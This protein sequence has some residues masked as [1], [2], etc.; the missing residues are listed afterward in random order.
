MKRNLKLLTILFFIPLFTSAQVYFSEIM[1]D[2]K[3]ADASSGGEWFE[4]QNTGS[5]S[6]DLTKLFFF[7]ND[8]NHG[9][10]AV[11]ASEIPPGGYAVISKDPAVFKSYFTNFSGLLFKSSFSLNDGEKLAIKNNKEDVVTN[12]NSVEYTSALGAKNDGNSLQKNSSGGWVFAT[13]TPGAG[14]ASAGSASNVNTN[15]EAVEQSS[16]FTTNNIVSSFPVEPQMIVEAG[17]SKT[18]VAGALITF[19]G[20]ALGLKKE[21]LENARYT[22]SL[23]DGILKDG[24]KITHTYRYPGEYIAVLEVSSGYFSGSDRLKVSVIKPE[25]VISKIGDA[26]DYF[27]EVTNNSKH[28]LDL[29]GWILKSQNEQFFIPKNTII[30]PQG[31]IIFSSL[32]TRLSFKQNDKPSLL[33]PS[34]ATAATF[35]DSAVAEVIKEEV[36]E[37]SNT[38]APAVV[39]EGEEK[40]FSNKNLAASVALASSG[41]GGEPLKQNQTFPVKWLLSVGV[42]SALAIFGV[43]FNARGVSGEKAELSADDFEIE[44]AE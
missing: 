8:T 25:I 40:G 35:G 6:V 23:G 33:Y 41:G 10:T 31:K 20:I 36:N 37:L 14:M 9:I 42:L 29:S 15:N 44:E 12:D 38:N 3:D 2:P 19:D 4:V 5:V 26:T 27:I 16:V 7:E 1:Y 24:K 11:G 21:P 30:I 34:G 32:T 22:W 17:S 18:T 43:M 13:P 39:K 28:E